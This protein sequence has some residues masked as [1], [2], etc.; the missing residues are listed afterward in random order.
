MG[1]GDFTS[2][3]GRRS[4]MAFCGTQDRFKLQ[5][6]MNDPKCEYRVISGLKSS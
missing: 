6:T 5:R 1:L 2:Q 3:R 4:G